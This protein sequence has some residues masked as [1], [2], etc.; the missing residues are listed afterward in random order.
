MI[1]VIY[2]VINFTRAKITISTSSVFK[3]LYDLS[4]PAGD[5]LDVDFL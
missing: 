1:N 2:K 3:R 4:A 5:A